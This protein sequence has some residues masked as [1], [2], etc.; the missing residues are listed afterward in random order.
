M[1]ENKLGARAIDSVE[2]PTNFQFAIS[3]SAAGQSNSVFYI[4]IRSSQPHSI[5]ILSRRNKYL[6]HN[7]N[8]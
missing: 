3:E 4:G 1:R 2:I 5:I 8:K 6:A 7:K